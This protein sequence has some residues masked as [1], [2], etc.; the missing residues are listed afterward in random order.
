VVTIGRRPLVGLLYSSA[1]PIVIDAAPHLVELLD[2]IPERLFYDVG[3]RSAQRFHEVSGAVDELRPY[4]A[5]RRT[6]GHG[7]GLSLP[8]DMPLDEALL[9]LVGGLHDALGFEWYSEHLSSFA[10][11]RGAVPNA[12]AGLGLPV[13]YDIEV[14]DMLAA[15]VD[16]VQG[17][18]GVRL[19]LENP[20]V[21]TP[22]PDCDLSEP[23]FL[24]ALSRRCG[25]GVLLDLHNLYANVRN[26]GIDPDAYLAELDLDNVVEIHLAG[27]SELF[28][29]YTDSH[30]ALSPPEV[31]RLAHEYAPDMPN[32]RAVV[33]EFHES[34]IDRLGV[35]AVVSELERMHE[36][37]DRW[38]PAGGTLAA[39]AASDGAG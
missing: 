24:N 1:A 25:S 32:L 20:A 27:G 21:F 9:D 13:P 3:P 28:G 5:A 26:H 8:S 18:L 14:L 23:E 15:K 36:L 6:A 35:A 37:V 38:P 22:V 29:H 4:A 33:F 12:Q 11:M 34:S 2:V 16:R 31:W 17:R 7:V 10:T 39:A 30:A 19:L